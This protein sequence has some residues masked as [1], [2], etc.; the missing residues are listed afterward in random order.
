MYISSDFN[1]KFAKY[2]DT[3]HTFWSRNLQKTDPITL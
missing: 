1:D 2:Y 3:S